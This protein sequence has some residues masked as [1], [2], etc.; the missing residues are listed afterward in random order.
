MKRI[1]LNTGI[2]LIPFLATSFKS[3]SQEKSIY[4]FK[5]E[6]VD[7]DMFDFQKLKGKKILIVN[8]AS[9]CGLTPQYE[10]LQEL[11]LQHG[12]EKFEIIAFPANNFA[13]QEPG[14]NKEI[15]DFCS[16]NFNIS[17]PI[18]A[19]LSVKGEDIAPIYKW[20]TKKSENGVLD[21]EVSWNFQ[22]FLIDEK[23]KVVKSIPPKT[24]PMDKIITEWITNK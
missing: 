16:I 4:D 6:T 14:S 21:T 9:K 3:Y 8:V 19:K 17:F 1:L 11:Y 2:F 5:V 24:D 20:L 7:G 18:M 22:K 15:K 13:K 23:G 12:N 10:R